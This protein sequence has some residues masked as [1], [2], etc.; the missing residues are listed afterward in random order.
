MSDA[1]H[2]FEIINSYVGNLRDVV[3]K[4]SLYIKGMVM[5]LGTTITVDTTY[6][7]A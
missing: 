3:T 7:N 2:L 1:T 5:V 4:A 6:S